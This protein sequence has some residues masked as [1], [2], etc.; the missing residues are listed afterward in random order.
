MTRLITTGLFA[1]L[2]VAPM[3]NASANVIRMEITGGLDCGVYTEEEVGRGDYGC[4]Q[5][6]DNFD[7]DFEPNEQGGWAGSAFVIRFKVDMAAPPTNWVSGKWFVGDWVDSISLLIG[8]PG[9]DFNLPQCLSGF[10]IVADDGASLCTGSLTSP[11]WQQVALLSA[12]E[13]A[14]FE[15]GWSLLGGS[16]WQ[17]AWQF[18]S[19]RR[20]SAL[21]EPGTL[22]LLGLGMAGL[23]LSRRRRAD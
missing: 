14:S 9:W 4:E 23:G 6:A 16:G 13:L 19:I 1:L 10:A 21:P 5:F 8:E 12:N 11:A 3:H 22:A 2:C 20:I 7:L 18:D 15:P 17:G